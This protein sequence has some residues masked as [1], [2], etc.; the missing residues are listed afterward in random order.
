MSEPG[1]TSPLRALLAGASAVVRAPLLIVTVTVVTMLMALPFAMVLGSR[2]HVA[3][4]S[5][6]PVA[7]S[8]TEID[9]DWWREFRA[10]ARGLESTFTPA[11]IG[12][13]APLDSISAVLDG[14]RPP[15][16]V[17]GPLV[18]SMV[19]W[20]FLWGGIL[21]RF[22]AGRGIGI[23]GFIR[24]GAQVTP[25][26]IAIAIAAAAVIVVL[27]LTVHAVLFGPVYRMLVGPAATGRDVFLIRVFLYLVFLAPLAL[28][29]LVADYARVTLV[30]GVAT[31]AGQALRAGAAFVGANPRAV[32]TLYVITALVFAAVT[33]AYGL[34]EISG[35]SRVGGWRAIAIGQAYIVLR[36]TIRLIVAA[37]E[38]RLFASRAMR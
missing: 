28:V 3:L 32:V 18:L 30:A 9:P 36:L 26:F 37:A 11:V 13:A 12:F 23:R 1:R 29:G 7:L 14:R 22:D 4:A 8:E 17:L 5:Q 25:R 19:A 38:L 31:S 33:I 20:A 15:L 6:P 2:I 27:Y 34:L 24:A 16:P 35:G 21:R 10:Q